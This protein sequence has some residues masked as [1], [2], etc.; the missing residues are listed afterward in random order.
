M[1]NSYEELLSKRIDNLPYS[2]KPKHYMEFKKNL[3]KSLNFRLTPD[4]PSF[5]EVMFGSYLREMGDKHIQVSPQLLLEHTIIM[6]SLMKGPVL[7]N[8]GD[9]FEY[10]MRKENTSDEYWEVL[11]KPFHELKEVFKDEEVYGDL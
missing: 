7:T 4:G 11:H 1:K 6:C 9:D 2:I 8:T 5:L 3:I 10:E